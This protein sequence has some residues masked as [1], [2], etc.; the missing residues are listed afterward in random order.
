M[1]AVLGVGG[2]GWGRGGCI[3]STRLLRLWV[4]GT[5]NNKHISVPTLSQPVQS[6]L[7]RPNIT[8]SLRVLSHLFLS[9]Y[10]CTT[11]I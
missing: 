8:I 10:V 2:G 11:D 9:V 1:H 6:T 5:S 7:P 4:R 3:A